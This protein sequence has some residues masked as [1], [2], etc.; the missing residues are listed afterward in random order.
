[1]PLIARMAGIEFNAAL[2][3]KSA[4]AGAAETQPQRAV[5]NLVRRTSC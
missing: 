3:T 1:V 2:Y 5:S 4:A